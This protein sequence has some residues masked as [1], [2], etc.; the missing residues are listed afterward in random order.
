M[1]YRTFRASGL[2]VA[3]IVT[4]LCV[5]SARAAIFA[6]SLNYQ[7]YANYIDGDTFASVDDGTLLPVNT[8]AAG[9]VSESATVEFNEAADVVNASA[10]A[11]A[12][13]TSIG[14]AGSITITG[15]APATAL[16]IASAEVI[17][18]YTPTGGVGTVE[19]SFSFTVTGTITGNLP[20]ATILAGA[21]VDLTPDGTSDIEGG[22]LDLNLI[23]TPVVGANALTVTTAPVTVTYGEAVELSFSLAISVGANEG[24][25]DLMSVDADFASTIVLDSIILS[26]DAT[27]TADSGAQVQT[28]VN[29]P[30]PA[31]AALTP[32]VLA[33]FVRRTRRR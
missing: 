16:A 13:F 2:A 7:A 12:D 23:E 10:L 8:A 17:D 28:V 15:S 6:P 33:M 5:A 32:V 3:V 30:T 1:G 26:E 19:M 4:T 18:F 9:P 24:D 25:A 20:A 22:T 27:V 29:I 31:A 21:V 14:A 11:N